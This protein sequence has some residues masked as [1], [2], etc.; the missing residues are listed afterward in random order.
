MTSFDAALVIIWPYVQA[1]L[2]TRSV[3]TPP[4]SRFLAAKSTPGSYAA[5]AASQ[6][7]GA[8]AAAPAPAD[9][10]RTPSRFA[11]S[12]TPGAFAFNG[13]NRTPGRD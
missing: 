12:R 1:T 3:A 8:A 5:A 10:V 6:D 7:Q 2:P 9:N 13:F 4:P 11:L